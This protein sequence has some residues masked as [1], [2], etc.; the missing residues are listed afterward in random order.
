MTEGPP[1]G[2]RRRPRP[3]GPRGFETV[4]ELTNE[5]VAGRIR[6]HEGSSPRQE[7]EPAAP[8]PTRPPAGRRRRQGR[9]TTSDSLL[10]LGLVVVGLVALRFLLPT[11]PIGVAA[12]NPPGGSQ[13]AAAPTTAVLP[14]QTW[15]P[16]SIQTLLPGVEPSVLATESVASP[17]ATSAPTAV[18]TVP[19]AATPTLKP[20]LTPKPTPKVTAPPTQAPGRPT[21]LVK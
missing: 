17:P 14:T 11:S 7:V 1:P 20:G 5:Q 12:S 2:P 13:V 8:R 6:G 3:R 18:A 21:L 10:V 15:P 4:P 9:T 16:G 19:P